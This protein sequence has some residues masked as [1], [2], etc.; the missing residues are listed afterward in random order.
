MN[1]HS[2]RV[3]EFEKIRSR[4]RDR[5]LTA[6][7]ARS[8]SRE[9]LETDE[10][11]LARLL[12]HVGVV[13]TA[14]GTGVDAPALSF[15]P[16]ATTLDRA[17]KEGSV[18]E[19]IDLAEIAAF[20]RST[21]LLHRYLMTA[22]GEAGT[23]AAMESV[24]GD[25]P[26]VSHV[27]ARLLRYVDPDGTVREREIPELRAIRSQILR[28]QQ[29]LQSTA[30]GLTSRDDVR[31][32]LS[33][34]VPTQR[35]GRTVIALKA[36]HRGKLPGIVH[37]VSGSGATVFIEPQE[38]VAR[39]NAVVEA[40]NRYRNELLKI[41]RDLTSFC[42]TALPELRAGL[43]W[44]VG[45]DRIYCRARFSYDFACERA[46]VAEG[47][48]TLRGARHPLLGETAVPINVEIPP[49]KRVLIVTGPNT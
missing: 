40:E 47:R 22:A 48:L 2:L 7:G 19:P 11:E 39:N 45:I 17:E 15:P 13:K 27:P 29:D 10:A 8:V 5:C 18:L 23:T 37:E 34:T 20:A 35:D 12:D 21:L 41:L 44:T 3:L 38:L 46:G 16:V 25:A 49:G 9:R 36:D 26:D 24:L 30:N 4:V 1:R 28:C 32:F 14:L 33:A 31:R 6:E 42:R 43:A